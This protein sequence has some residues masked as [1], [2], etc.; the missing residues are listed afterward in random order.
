MPHESAWPDAEARH[1]AIEY[2]MVGCQVVVPI[3]LLLVVLLAGCA[4]APTHLQVMAEEGLQLRKRTHFSSS[5]EVKL[6][7]AQDLVA[8]AAQYDQLMNRSTDSAYLL[9]AHRFQREERESALALMR[10]AAEDYLA[11]Q[12][13]VHARST[14][15]AVVSA[16]W[17]EDQRPIRESAE[18]SL[19]LLEGLQREQSR[20]S[21]L[22]E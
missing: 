17:E 12:D 11:R 7:V 13:T 19:A 3:M 20:A 22:R 4:A 15:H 18:S 9:Q 1:R 8:H 2:S 16:F 10:E 5:P 6:H 14:Y 21:A